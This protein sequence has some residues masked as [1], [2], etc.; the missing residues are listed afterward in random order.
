MSAGLFDF[1]KGNPYPA[2]GQNTGLGSNDIYSR[3]T[4]T[5]FFWGIFAVNRQYGIFVNIFFFGINR[6]H[7]AENF[8]SY[9]VCCAEIYNSRT[10]AD[11]TYIFWGDIYIMS[12]L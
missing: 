2:E 11:T 8:Y 5:N 10:A 1:K 3:S 9:F 4:F 12:G 6:L 7:T